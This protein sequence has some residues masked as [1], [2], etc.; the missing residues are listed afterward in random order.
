M[1]NLRKKNK[2]TLYEL[3]QLVDMQD[4]PPESKNITLFPYKEQHLQIKNNS[5]ASITDGRQMV[6]YVSKNITLSYNDKIYILFENGI[7]EMDIRYKRI[8]SIARD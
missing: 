1:E 3:L 7:T 8:K 4:I 6:K 5:K 2:I